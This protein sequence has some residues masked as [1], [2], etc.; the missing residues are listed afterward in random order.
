MSKMVHLYIDNRGERAADNGDLYIVSLLVCEIWRE[1][2]GKGWGSPS[3]GR[4]RV[5]SASHI[6]NKSPPDEL[7]EGISM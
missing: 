3:Y 6:V 5:I 1:E 2:A 4:S 7:Y